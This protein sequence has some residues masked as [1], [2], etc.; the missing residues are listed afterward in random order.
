MKIVYRTLLARHSL[1]GVLYPTRWR[2]PAR[3]KAKIPPRGLAF[4]TVRV[5][6]DCARRSLQITHLCHRHS[7]LMALFLAFVT[8]RVTSECARRSL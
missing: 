2:K 7:L 5:T 4:V 8:L 3:V 6:T 1:R